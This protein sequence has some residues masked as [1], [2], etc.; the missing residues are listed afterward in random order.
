MRIRAVLIALVLAACGPA[1]TPA[2]L[3]RLGIDNGTTLTLTIVVN[4]QPLHDIPPG[5]IDAAIDTSHAP[6]LPWKLEARSPRG[7][8][9][10]ML[11][12]NAPQDSSHTDASQDENVCGVLVMWTGGGG[13]PPKS[14]PSTGVPSQ[15]PGFDCVRG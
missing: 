7:A 10:D 6:P 8:V 1:P 2:P 4:G 14:S 5:T 15:Y 9:L 11:Y 12:L 3:V 13:E